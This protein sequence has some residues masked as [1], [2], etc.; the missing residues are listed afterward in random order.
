MRNEWGVEGWGHTMSGLGYG[1]RRVMY[2]M[3]RCLH[4]HTHQVRLLTVHLCR[5]HLLHVH[6]AG[7]PP[8]SCRVTCVRHIVSVMCSVTYVAHNAKQVV[9]VGINL[10]EVWVCVQV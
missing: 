1:R 6:V 7:P 8:H 3:K 9:V 10:R 2:A 4:T 5:G